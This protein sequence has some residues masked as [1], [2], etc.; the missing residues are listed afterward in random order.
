MELDLTKY[1]KE[2][3]KVVPTTVE[4]IVI[5]IQQMTGA[6]I[7][8]PTAF[9][10]LKIHLRVIFECDEHN[11]KSHHDIALQD[12]DKLDNRS[13]LGQYVN[14]YGEIAVGQKIIAMAGKKGFY[15]VLL[16]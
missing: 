9:D 14:K 7:F 8:G 13:Q 3:V 12:P 16:E 15:K 11:I 5:D 4:A 10:P 6:E 1:K 2:N